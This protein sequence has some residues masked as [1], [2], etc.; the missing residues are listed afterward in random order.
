MNSPPNA[1]FSHTGFLVRDLDT[2]IAFYTRVLGLVVTDRGPYYKGGEIAFMSRSA[3]EHH[4]VVLASGRTDA[5][6]ASTINQLS[7]RVDSLEDLQTFHRRLLTEAVDEYAPRNHGNAWSIY[8]ADP[9]GNRIELYAATPWHVQQP[10]GRPLD[11]S[12][13]AAAIRQATHALLADNPTLIGQ[14]AWAQAFEARLKASEPALPMA[15]EKGR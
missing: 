12:L 1:Q 11:L 5:L 13:S 7:F 14:A 9:E 10:F 2:M 15:P 3:G 8:F 6:H 4:Q